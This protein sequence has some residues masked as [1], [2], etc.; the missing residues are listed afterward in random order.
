MNEVTENCSNSL[1][2]FLGELSSQIGILSVGAFIMIIMSLKSETKVEEPLNTNEQITTLLH[3]NTVTNHCLDAI[4]QSRVNLFNILT[5]QHINPHE[6][7]YIL[8]P[9]IKVTT[10]PGNN[11]TGSPTATSAIFTISPLHTPVTKQ[12]LLRLPTQSKSL[13]PPLI[14][15][16][17]S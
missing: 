2:I 5:N 4:S 14:T 8:S 17:T 13:L 1:S 3:L 6:L 12:A 15:P 10:I 9:T 11:T 7:R 16:R